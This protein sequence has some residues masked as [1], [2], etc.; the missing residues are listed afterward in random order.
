MNTVITHLKPIFSLA[1]TRN[2][3]SFTHANGMTAVIRCVLMMLG[4][5]A[6]VGVIR[7]QQ[8]VDPLTITNTGNVGIG[9]T[10][11][12]NKLSVTGNAD[13]SGNVGIGTTT[14]VN[15]LSVAGN[16]DVSGNVGIGTSSP[17]NKLSVAGNADFNGAVGI[18]TSSLGESKFKIANSKTD[19][20]HFRF[21]AEGAGEFEFVGW[22]KGWNINSKTSGK[23]L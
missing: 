6:G 19:F 23:N 3:R 4:M 16:A 14:P 13:V 10:A 1:R 12:A 7:A 15:K 17:T 5:L 22:D 21:G 8:K 11:P 20:A 18:G 9:T 2:W